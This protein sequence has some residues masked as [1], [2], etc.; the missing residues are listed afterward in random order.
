VRPRPGREAGRGVLGPLARRAGQE[1][2]LDAR[3]QG[4]TRRLPVE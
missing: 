4:V 3:G 2:G 1:Q